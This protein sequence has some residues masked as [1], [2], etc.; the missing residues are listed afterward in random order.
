MKDEDDSGDEAEARHLLE[1]R[2]EQAKYD[3]VRGN[4]DQS[5]VE[6]AADPGLAAPLPHHSAAA[7][8]P[9][10]EHD[11]GGG[12]PR[13]HGRAV[14]LR[15]DLRRGHGGGGHDG[16]HDLRGNQPSRHRVD[17]VEVM[18]QP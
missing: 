2:R 11:G 15:H 5:V 13:P 6:K 17:G 18:I 7:G 10:A 12:R 9:P 8:R 3:A 14:A 16:H 1:K 4:S